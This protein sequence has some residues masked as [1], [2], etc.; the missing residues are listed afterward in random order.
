MAVGIDR[1]C[2]LVVQSRKV[3]TCD[4]WPLLNVVLL[5]L[6]GHGVKVAQSAVDRRVPVRFR[7]VRPKGMSYSLVN[8]RGS[9]PRDRSSN[10]LIPINLYMC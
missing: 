3:L 10:L 4:V 7:V 5:P 6:T 8:I 9:R 1:G 2:A